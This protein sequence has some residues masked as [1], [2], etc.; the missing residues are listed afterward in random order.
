MHEQSV[1]I[2]QPARASRLALLFHGVGTSAE[3]LVP[4]GDAIVRAYPDAMVVSV[5]APH[6][7]T[8][9]TGRE[10]FS[11]VGITEQDRPARIAQSMPLFRQSVAYWQ[12][13]GGI[14]AAH[15]ALVGF[16]QGAIMTLESTQDEAA[17][18]A[19]KAVALAGRFAELVRSVPGGLRYHL[20][21]GAQDGVVAPQFAR[22][23]AEGIRVKGGSVTLDVLDGLGHSVDARVLRLLLAYLD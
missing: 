22:L 1:V 14:D 21:H 2:A 15:T 10:W 12:Q 6:P 20:I 11:V 13:R 17:P 18:L 4:L 19:G 5:G 8:L 23:A 16:S 7:S 9:G 3:N